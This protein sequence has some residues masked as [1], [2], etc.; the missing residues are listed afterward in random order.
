MDVEGKLCTTEKECLDKGGLINRAQNT[1]VS[2][3]EG[4]EPYVIRE[5]GECLSKDECSQKSDFVYNDDLGRC[6]RKTSVWI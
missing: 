6:L 2:A 3:C 1:C 4:S 5:T